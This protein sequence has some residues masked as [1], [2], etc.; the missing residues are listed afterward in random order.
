MNELVSQVVLQATMIWRRRWYVLA[1]TWFVCVAGWALIP[2]LPDTYKSSA[3]VYV[4]TES[5]L[6]PLLKGLAVETDPDRELEIMQRTLL[7]RPNLEKV[8]RMT[9]LDLTVN[10]P[11]ETE[12]L[13]D[14]L[15][16]EVKIGSETQ[17]LFSISYESPDPQLARRVV[18]A[19]LTIYVETNLGSSRAE[20]DTARQFIDEQIRDYERQLDA[21]EQ[22]LANFKQAN[23]GLLPG[24][25]GYY[26]RLD[27]ARAVLEAARSQLQ[28]A[29][30][31]REELQRQLA[32]VPQFYKGVSTASTDSG[33]PSDLYVRILEIEK[34]IDEMLTRYTDKHPD[35]ITA[36]RRLEALREQVQSQNDA[37]AAPQSE[38]DKASNT[39]NPLYEQIKL[40]LVTVES[41]IATL[42]GGVERAEANV[43]ELEKL[44][45]RVPAVEA[46]LAK[47]NR[48]YDVIKNNYEALLTRRESAK[49][50]EER[51]TKGEKV[52]FR[53]VDPPQVPNIPSGPPRMLYLSIVL[54]AGLGAGIG[55]G[56]LIANMHETYFTVDS[57]KQAFAV[58]VLGAVSSVLSPRQRSW[59]LIKV[60]S[61]AI[62]MAGLFGTYSGLI[63]VEDAYGLNRAVPA[64]LANKISQQLEKIAP[65]GQN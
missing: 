60:A 40:Q 63:Y 1:V 36:Q 50:S 65:T 32:S 56:A 19:M 29:T 22:R 46:E 10:G 48:D 47:L 57:L 39:P 35:V 16:E 11:V 15:Q 7:S 43:A 23:M 8:A 62:V 14:R 54:L 4:D 24:D 30:A 31:S 9:D 61:F 42:K 52:L 51:E 3:R 5:L 18:Q 38:D 55:F 6:G 27:K 53:V 17:N 28:D 59:G 45:N 12:K 41:S 44:A 33:P 26:Q 49:I 64:D 34:S 2:F 58:P 25:T 20:M 13:I 21:A 37:A